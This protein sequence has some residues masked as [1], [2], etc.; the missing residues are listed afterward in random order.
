MKLKGVSLSIE[1]IIVIV[2]CVLVLAVVVLFYTGIFN[3]AALGLTSE[4]NL[5]KECNEWRRH[6]YSSDYF[7]SGNCS[8]LNSNFNSNATKA[9][10]YCTGMKGT[11]PPN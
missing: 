11:E 2:I 1:T 10:E 7:F 5:W 4:A 9:K 8:N 3:P 6:S